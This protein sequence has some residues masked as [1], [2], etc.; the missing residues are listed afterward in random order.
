MRRIR[1]FV[2][3]QQQIL[4]G[5]CLLGISHIPRTHTSQRAIQA[6][7]GQE[8]EGADDYNSDALTKDD[9][10]LVCALMTK[11][12]DWDLPPTPPAPLSTHKSNCSF[13]QI[14]PPQ[15]AWSVC[16]SSFGTRH[17]VTIH[18]YYVQCFLSIGIGRGRVTRSVSSQ[19]TDLAGD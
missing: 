2:V 18:R 4:L 16:C 11:N 7:I 14:P 8:D 1:T 17:L 12:W 3:C 10:F 15:T 13:T 9:K 6:E 5:D 19:L